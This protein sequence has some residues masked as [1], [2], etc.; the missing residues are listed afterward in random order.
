MLEILEFL[1][2]AE[3][4]GKEIATVV[5]VQAEQNPNKNVAYEARLLKRL[6]YKLKE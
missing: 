2:I 1:D 4:Y 6:F 3:Q 5:S